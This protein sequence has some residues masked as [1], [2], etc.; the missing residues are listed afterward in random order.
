MSIISDSIIVNG[1]RR[2]CRVIKILVF[3]KEG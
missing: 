3:L 2:V 1:Y